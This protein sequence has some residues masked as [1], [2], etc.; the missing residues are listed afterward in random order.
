MILGFSW[1]FGAMKIEG[2]GELEK[3]EN[4]NKAWNVTKNMKSFGKSSLVIA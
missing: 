4:N 2:V 1:K 3:K